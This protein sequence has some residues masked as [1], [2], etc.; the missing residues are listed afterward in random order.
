MK[1]I[2]FLLVFFCSGW[3][4]GIASELGNYLRNQS[5]VQSVK[6]M[7]ANTFFK[8]AYILFVRQPLDHRDPGKGTFLQSVFISLREQNSPVVM[9]TEGYAAQYGAS[10]GFIS[11]LCPILGAN[12]VVIEHRFFGESW[13]DSLQWEYLTVENAAADHH[14]VFQLLKPFF[15]GKWVNTGISK[16]GQTAL[17]HRVFY[18]EDVDL[19]VSYVAPMNFGVEDGRHEPYIAHVSGT[20]KAR[21]KVKAFQSE[22]LLRRDQLMPMFEK[23]IQDK[24]YTYQAVLPEIY[25]MTAL[26]YSF[27]FWQWGNDPD[28]IPAVVS[29]DSVIFT[30]WMK[31]SSPDY[32]SKEELEKIGPFYVQ[33]ARELGYYSYDTRP[34]R[35][36]LSIKSARGYLAR[37]F[38]PE[39]CRPVFDPSS[40]WKS[41]KFLNI[42]KLPMIFI[43]GKNDPWTASG[44]II[45]KKSSILKIIQEGGSHGTRISNLDVT[46]KQKVLNKLYTVIPVKE[47]VPEH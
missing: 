10:A 7:T 30:H 11:E 44:V 31:V 28:D 38:L 15:Q 17:L 46:N 2:I 32:F 13:P 26:E 39:N 29:S 21:L 23:V 12:Q 37:L 27:A 8:E 42:T 5:N 9:V 18:P 4:S 25:D 35:R 40:A 19:T 33:A 6:E 34:F 47:P 16:G 1:H 14:A 36:F 22:V 41:Q 3:T 43:Y 24:K 20:R 45:P